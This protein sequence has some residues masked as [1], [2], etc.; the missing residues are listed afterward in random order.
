MADRLNAGEYLDLDQSLWSANGVYRLILQADGNL[1]LYDDQRSLWASNTEGRRV[2]AAV[3][4]ED[5]NFVLQAGSRAAWASGT[6][7]SP[8]ARLVVQDDGNVV[9]YA[10]GGDALWATRTA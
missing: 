8:G 3:M 10:Q 5:G 7:G 1:V 6:D 9:V 4:Q 2:N